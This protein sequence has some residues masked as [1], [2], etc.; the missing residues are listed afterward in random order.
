MNACSLKNYTTAHELRAEELQI[1][2]RA[3]TD[4]GSGHFFQ[5]FDLDFDRGS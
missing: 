4:S 5:A 2:T 3:D 1:N